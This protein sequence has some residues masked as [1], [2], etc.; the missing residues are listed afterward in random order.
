[1]C[2]CFLSFLSHFGKFSTEFHNNIIILKGRQIWFCKFEELVGNYSLI[3]PILS[4]LVCL[5]FKEVE[6]YY[7]FV[8]L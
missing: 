5:Y 3:D 4:Y 6:D 8:L 2:I 7:K 1:M